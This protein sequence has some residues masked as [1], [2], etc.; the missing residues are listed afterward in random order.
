MLGMHKTHR[1]EWGLTELR[2]EWREGKLYWLLVIYLHE[3]T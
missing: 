3:V 2:N 1:H